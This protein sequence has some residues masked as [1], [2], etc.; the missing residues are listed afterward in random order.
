MVRLFILHPYSTL[1]PQSSA[2][3]PMSKTKIA[4][5]QMDVEIG[6]V[7][8]NRRRIT[9]KIRAA[10][11]QGAELVIFPECALTGY[12]FASLEEAQPFAEPVDGKSATLISEACREANIHAVV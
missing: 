5:V 10:A 11:D 8:A 4:C 1:S 9:E 2:L 12:C 3:S 6:E 7:A